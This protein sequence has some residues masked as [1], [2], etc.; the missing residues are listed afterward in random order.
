LSRQLSKDLDKILTS[1]LRRSGGA[2][3]G[4]DLKSYS[5][6]LIKAVTDDMA[7]DYVKTLSKHYIGGRSSTP[8]DPT[9][10][11]NSYLKN[12]DKHIEVAIGK[13]STSVQTKTKGKVQLDPADIKELSKAMSS[14]FKETVS[15]LVPKETGTTIRE[16]SNVSRTLMSILKK[17]EGLVGSIKGMKKSGGG[18]DITEAPKVAENFKKLASS[19]EKLPAEFN[20]L[21]ESAKKLI[22]EQK[23]LLTETKGMIDDVKREVRTRKRIT[24]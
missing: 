24:Y 22:G 2:S 16:L 13:I 17:V 5:K 15:R 9:K 7:K 11:T 23:A 14:H 20:N 18:I 19:V 3:E 10:A 1:V 4:I 12:I 21:R 6:G 8:S